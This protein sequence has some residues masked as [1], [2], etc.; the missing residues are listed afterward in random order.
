MRLLP[1]GS[2]PVSRENERATLPSALSCT[3][4]GFS[5]GSAYANTRWA[6]TPPFHPYPA[7]SGTTFR[8]CVRPSRYSACLK[9]VPDGAGRYIFCDTLRHRDFS[10]AAPAYSTRH[11]A[12]WCSDFPPANLAIHQ[13]SSAIGRILAGFSLIASATRITETIRRFQS[14][15]DASHPPTIG[16]AMAMN[17]YCRRDR[18]SSNHA[19]SG[20]SFGCRSSATF[21]LVC[22]RGR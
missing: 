6:L 16:D 14:E 22:R 1:E 2:F 13:R 20:Q 15:K 4:W 18:S 7:P 17:S 3:T 9:V 5:C 10:T 11:A 12:V 8:S 21:A 19:S